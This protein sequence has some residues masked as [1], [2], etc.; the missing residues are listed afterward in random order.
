MQTLMHFLDYHFQ[1][2]LILTN[3]HRKSFSCVKYFSRM[4]VWWPGISRDIESKVRECQ[5]CQL[6]QSTPPVTPLQPWS[7]PTSP[8]TRLH[9]DYAGPFEGK[10]IL[11]LVDTHSKWIEAIHTPNAT[12]T[13]VEELRENSVWYPS[14][15]CDQ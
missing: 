3:L 13:I 10:M 9:L 11:V 4:Y 12:S 2:V 7:W 1:V 14:D 6:Q 5:Q 8:W 15:Y